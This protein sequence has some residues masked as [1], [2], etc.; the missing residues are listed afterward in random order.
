MA[1]EERPAELLFPDHL[2]TIDILFFWME[3]HNCGETWLSTCCVCPR[4]H[5]VD[6]RV[7]DAKEIQRPILSELFGDNIHY[8]FLAED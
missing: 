4:C 6:F 2:E 3:C 7:M 1:A 8:V 5:R